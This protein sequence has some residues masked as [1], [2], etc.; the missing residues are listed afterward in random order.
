MSA[1]TLSNQNAGTPQAL[2]SSFKSILIAKAA[3]GATTLRR[4]W[5]MEW[6]IGATDVPN[7]TDCPIL[8][9]I[10]EQTA[11]GTATARSRRGPND[12][13]GGDA[14][15]LGTYQANATA[16]GTVTASSSAWFLGLNQR[17]SYR[18][19]MRDEYHSLVV[20]AVNLKGFAM[21]AKSPNYASTVG[22]RVPGQGIRRQT[23]T[24]SRPAAVRRRDR[25]IEARRRQNAQSPRLCDHQPIP[26]VGSLQ[27]F[28]TV[29]C[30]HCGGC[31]DDASS[32]MSGTLEVMVFRR[33]RHALHEGSR[34]LP[35]LHEAE[36]CPRCVGKPCEQSFQV[37]MDARRGGRAPLHL[38]VPAEVC[39]SHAENLWQGRLYA[40]GADPRRT[41]G[42]AII[43]TSSPIIAPASLGAVPEPEKYGI[44]VE[45]ED[46]G[47][48]QPG[49][50][51]RDQRRQPQRFPDLLRRLRQARRHGLPKDL[52]GMVDAGAD[53]TRKK[54]N[55]AA[56]A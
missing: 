35:L 19:Q 13:G 34:L 39:D 3:T 8:W 36:V 4:A 41:C 14:A 47:D 31:L 15:A 25:S 37:V 17:A 26:D 20:P 43:M 1:Y 12:V 5:L 42:P 53:W 50:L 23:S 46:C 51:R 32:N 6:E 16:E 49:A 11:D 24:R 9:D 52:P 44:P 48:Q 28:D 21:R 45:G 54:W 10:S 56:G 30:I 33:R 55:E 7:A 38:L 2:S 22:W 27:E 40:A 29:S 18:V